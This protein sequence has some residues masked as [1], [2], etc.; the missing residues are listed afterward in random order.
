[1]ETLYISLR[2]L[3]I[4]VPCVIRA[5]IGGL[6]YYTYIIH[7]LYIYNVYN[8]KFLT[9]HKEHF[10]KKKKKVDMRDNYNKERGRN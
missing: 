4:R 2:V 7:T 5:S 10:G 8:C 1:M 6:R 9:V 3:S